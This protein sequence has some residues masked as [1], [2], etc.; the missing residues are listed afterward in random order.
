MIFNGDCLAF[1][2]DPSDIIRRPLTDQAIRLFR[3]QLVLKLGR[4]LQFGC[5][6]RLPGFSAELAQQRDFDQL[7]ARAR[8]RSPGIA[9]RDRL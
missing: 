9:G 5:Q 8:H 3:Q 4:D 2:R 7:T 1:H 6:Y